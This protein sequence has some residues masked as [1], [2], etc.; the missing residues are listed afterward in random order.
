MSGRV[1]ERR[2][3]LREGL[4]LGGRR[5][6]REPGLLGKAMGR[7]KGEMKGDDGEVLVGKERRKA[8]RSKRP[9]RRVL[10]Q[11]ALYLMVVNMPSE[12]EMRVVKE[13]LVRLEQGEDVS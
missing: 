6:E 8:K 3:G 2:R 11:D 13:G 4:T 7:E 1:A 10:K 12:E 9:M 5:R